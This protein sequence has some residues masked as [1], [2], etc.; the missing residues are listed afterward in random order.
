MLVWGL[1]ILGVLILVGVGISYLIPQRGSASGTSAAAK[2]P[3]P[4]RSAVASGQSGQ[5]LTP[6]TID[7][8]LPA[9]LNAGAALKE[10]MSLLLMDVDHRPGHSPDAE[11]LARVHGLLGQ[12][13][14][15]GKDTLTRYGPTGFALLVQDMDASHA[16]ALAE[17]IRAGAEGLAGEVTLSVGATTW[18]PTQPHD[19]MGLTAAADFALFAS[20][21]AGGNRASAVVYPVNL[22]ETV[23]LS[24]AFQI[25]HGMAAAPEGR[26]R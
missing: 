5:P 22:D 11:S 18:Y 14:R 7:P 16:N 24:S 3:V 2:S 20:K 6:G 23:K 25:S 13:V 26:G 1:V 19:A 4:S 9:A 15:A 8:A 21:R 17:T 12:W 10:P